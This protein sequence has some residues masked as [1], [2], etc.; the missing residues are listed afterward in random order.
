MADVQIAP[1]DAEMARASEVLSIISGAYSAKVVGQERL[2]T[3]L[4]TALVA[5]GHILLESVPG[6]A[7]TTAATLSMASP[8]GIPAGVRHRSASASSITRRRAEAR[9]R[10]VPI[11]NGDQKSYFTLR[12]Y[13]RGAP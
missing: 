11:P 9:R 1:T 3:S 2:R 6:L 8:S 13:C 10:V 4:L 7:K 5:G 12:L